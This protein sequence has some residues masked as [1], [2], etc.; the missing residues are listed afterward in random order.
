MYSCSFEDVIEATRV[1]FQF[2][3]MND[4]TP[5]NPNTREGYQKER[6]SP[7]YLPISKYLS[8][9]DK[10]DTSS[11]IMC[12]HPKQKSE[13]FSLKVNEKLQIYLYILAIMHFNS[14]CQL[15]AILYPYRIMKLWKKDDE[16]FRMSILK[17]C[18][19]DMN[20]LLLFALFICFKLR[21]WPVISMVLL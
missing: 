18:D 13:S 4:T 20:C 6:N 9:T 11:A 8:I 21:I 1:T 19:T 3:Y 17:S 2:F 10:N 12:I 7:S 16:D 14:L 5:T 15:K